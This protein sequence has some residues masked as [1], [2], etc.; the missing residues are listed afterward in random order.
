M[1]DFDTIII[2][3][4]H[5]GLVCAGYLARQGQKVLVLDSQAACG[6]LASTHE[7]HPGYKASVVHRVTHFQRKIVTDLDLASHG[8]AETAGQAPMIGLARDPTQHVTLD[9][10]GPSGVPDADRTAF[11]AYDARLAQ[12]AEML[13]GFWLKTVPPL[14][15]N[16]LPEMF[17]YA[18][19]GWK[20]RALGKED[21]RELLRIVTLPM[22]DLVEEHFEHPML[23]AM[24]CW[25]GLVGTRQAPRS[26][27]NSVLQLLYR[28]PSKKTV[29][30]THPGMVVNALRASAESRGVEVHLSTPVKQIDIATNNGEQQVHGVVLESGERISAD[31]VVSSA[32][33]KTT[34][35]KLL[36]IDHLEV[37]FTNRIRRIRTNGLVAKL[38]LALD[39]APEFTGVDQLN[40]RLLITP[41]MA[42]IETAFNAAKYGHCPDE[43]VMEI[44]I[45]TLQDPSLAPAGKHVLSAQIMYVPHENAS[46][47]SD[48]A[49]NALKQSI[50]DRLACYAPGIRDQV[51]GSEL[52]LPEDVELRH[53]VTGGHWHHGEFALD[54]LLMMRPTY[55]AAQYRTPIDGL[56]L[57][58]AGSHP[59]G[60][61]TGAPGHNAAKEMLK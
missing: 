10:Q 48:E 19:L 28:T 31:R 9:H 42:T 3:A 47:W 58:G 45:P 26:P 7:F 54:Q 32:D 25:D 27:N 53:G 57:C 29:A 55:E 40:G 18:Q 49:R 11:R 30:A 24:L 61:I 8:F 39:G 21:M 56:W 59:G 51:V 17:S 6:G 38:H 14:G 52:L 60:D 16:S 12:F 4:G 50:M 36:G 5:N 43:P 46:G 1:A 41:D 20:L 13:S 15:N 23:K 33:P 44:A 35:T 34:F 2:G 37:E 22:Q